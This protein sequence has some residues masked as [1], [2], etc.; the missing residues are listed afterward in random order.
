M[1]EYG[2]KNERDQQLGRDR[3]EDELTVTNST[4]P[5]SVKPLRTRFSLTILLFFGR[6]EAMLFG[7]FVMAAEGLVRILFLSPCV[8]YLP[9]SPYLSGFTFGG[10]L[11][12]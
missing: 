9:L 4:A 8:F 12:E 10:L 2:L 6:G 5:E 3:K 1:C 11:L 7:S